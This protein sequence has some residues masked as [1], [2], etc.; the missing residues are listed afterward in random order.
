M[1]YKILFIFEGQ[2]T[3]PKI[4][5][6]LQHHFFSEDSSIIYSVFG[7]NI[8][9]LYDVLRRDEHADVFE[10]LKEQM[11][12]SQGLQDLD[13]S[14]IGEIY[15]F[16]DH[17][18]HDTRADNSKILNLLATF[19]NETDN[20]LLYINYPMVEAIKELEPFKNK[21]CAI[22]DNRRYKSTF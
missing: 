19:N 7:S 1:S 5:D 21:V 11:P 17:D 15:L 10:V 20:G 4:G 13:S 22:S 3:E 2:K 16:F 12:S 8:Y 9:S 14:D 18:G 6:C